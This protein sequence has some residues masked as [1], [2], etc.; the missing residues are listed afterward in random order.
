YK[1]HWTVVA[2]LALLLAAGGSAADDT[3]IY[4]LHKEIPVASQPMIMFSLDY[5]PN[6]GSTVCQSGE[7]DFLV[8]EGFLPEKGSYTFFEVLRASLQKVMKPLEG[9]RVGLML[10]HDNKTSCAGPTKTIPGCSHGG[11]IAMGFE[12]LGG[13][14]PN[15]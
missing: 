12:W 8:D 15:G 7:C 1:A 11:A 3:D 9:V 14:A 10:N 2:T 13:A 4:L 6:L 5:R